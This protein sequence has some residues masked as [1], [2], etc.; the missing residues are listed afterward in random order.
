MPL[1]ARCAA[2]AGA[3]WATPCP[4]AAPLSPASCSLRGNDFALDGRP[5]AATALLFM[6]WVYRVCCGMPRAS[7]L[8]VTGV[9]TSASTLSGILKKRRASAD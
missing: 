9:C 8:V 1:G 5:A 6:V 2:P 7:R 3:V 4:A